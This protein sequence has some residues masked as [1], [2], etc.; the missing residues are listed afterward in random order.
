MKSINNIQR[1]GTI[2][3]I[4]GVKKSFKVTSIT[5]LGVV[6]G[7]ILLATLNQ[8]NV[9]AVPSPPHKVFGKITHLVDGTET[10]LA[11]GYTLQSRI[12]RSGLQ[13]HY[14]E[15][16]NAVSG[17]SSTSATTH[18]ATTSDGK[19]YNFGS[20]SASNFR[21][22]ADDPDTNNVKEGGTANEL[23]YFYVNNVLAKITSNNGTAVD[24]FAIPFETG[25]VNDLTLR[26]WNQSTS[27]FDNIDSTPASASAHSN[28]N[29]C[30]TKSAELLVVEE[31]GGGGGG[32]GGGLPGPTATPQIIIM[33]MAATVA[34][35]ATE[36][37]GLT[38]EEAAEAF[39][40]STTD[41]IAE[42][43]VEVTDTKAAAILDILTDD[44]AAAVIGIFEDAK[45]AT[46][47][48]KLT[49]AK[50]A[51]V[52]GKVTEE[53]AI[54]IIELVTASKSAAILES[55]DD[56][57]VA[58]IISSITEAKAVEIIELISDSKAATTIEKITVT[59]AA[60]IAEGI[61]SSKAASVFSLVTPQVV[62]EIFDSIKTSTVSNII[63]EMAEESLVARLP[64]MTAEKMFAVDPAILFKSMP[65]APTEQLVAETA[66]EVP[67]DLPAP[68]AVQSSDAPGGESI[69]LVEKTKSGHWAGLVG[70]PK[71]IDKILGKFASDLDNVNVIVTNLTG[72]P[73][74]ITAIPGNDIVSDYFDVEVSNTSDGD[75]VG[76][77][78]TF[79]IDKSWLEVNEIHKWSI[80][81]KRFD[82]QLNVWVPFSSKRLSETADRIYYSSVM[83]GFSTIAV[84]GNKNISDRKFEVSELKIRPLIPTEGKQV[85]I[86]AKVSNL[87]STDQV[88][89]A[90]VWIDSTVEESKV[91][92]IAANGSDTVTFNLNKPVGKYDVRVE[93]LLGS[94]SVG[95]APT[96]T[97][98]PMVIT[99]KETP[100][101][102][103]EV[104]APATTVPPTATP[105]PSAPATAVPPTATP[106]PAP[107]TAPTAIAPTA[108]PKTAPTAVP[109]TAVPATATPKP[110]AP[111]TAVPVIT[112]P[113]PTAT[114]ALTPTPVPPSPVTEDDGS[115][116]GLFI[117]IVVISILA[118]G[119]GLGFM[120]F[121]NKS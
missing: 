90:N 41:V 66:P 15:N 43:L 96:P 6:I 81:L 1:S 55:V 17:N 119:G 58:A 9:Y 69:Y 100:V 86:S 108:T 18:D 30:T 116:M 115:N 19:I 27:A 21:V 107:V 110:P 40:D 5:L 44:K 50:A 12:T 92:S 29:A 72:I 118:V 101:K 65:N 39:K 95:S 97:K 46:V 74:G 24:T 60:T 71:P 53:K 83:P 79:Y 7:V 75:L 70:S 76:V 64:E 51:A 4:N 56:D 104:A 102:K 28:D 2:N 48:E 36:V 45:A 117:A 38:A 84:T 114:P 32:G 99:V 34:L 42:T 8:D 112:A 33:M 10:V 52:I 59:K 103:E 13:S 78:T 35:T 3:S 37:E 68:S 57:R 89:P 98:V 85:T 26:I 93:Q 91:L 25:G 67:A 63:I 23:I 121:R 120:V 94:F 109:P 77:H 105:R 111:A 82:D 54:A 87:T 62:G 47:V 88:Y 20:V 16:V 61:T 31:S 14:G 73:S 106:K 22:C 80:E 11:S 49:T 113:E